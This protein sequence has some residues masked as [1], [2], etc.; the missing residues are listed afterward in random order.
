MLAHA[1]YGWPLTFST[2]PDSIFNITRGKTMIVIPRETVPLNTLRKAEAKQLPVKNYL[3]KAE[4]DNLV[5]VGDLA[6]DA[7]E[8]GSRPAYVAVLNGE[9]YLIP[10]STVSASFRPVVPRIIL[11]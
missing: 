5:I 7:I 10:F 9:T 1:Q 4:Y 2:G 11:R 6:Y 3:S 8:R